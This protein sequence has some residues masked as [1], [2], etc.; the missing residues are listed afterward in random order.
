MSSKFILSFLVT[1][2]V[3]L[4]LT[5]DPEQVCEY[6]SDCI[7]LP[8]DCAPI[9]CINQQFSSEYT[10][11]EICPMIFSTCAAYSPSSCEC[12]KNN[13]CVNLNMANNGCLPLTYD[14]AVSIKN[15]FDSKNLGTYE[16]RV[17]PLSEALEYYNQGMLWNNTPVTLGP[18]EKWTDYCLLLSYRVYYKRDYGNVFE[19]FDGLRVFL[20]TQTS[21]PDGCGLSVKR[22]PNG[23]LVF[24]ELPDCEFAPC[25]TNG[26]LI[27]FFSILCIVLLCLCCATGLCCYCRKKKQ[28]T[29]TNAIPMVFQPQIPMNSMAQ[30]QPTSPSMH[31]IQQYIPMYSTPQ[32]I[33]MYSVPESTTQELA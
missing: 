31:P 29:Q 27:S 10:P 19:T 17:A 23:K 1:T 5:Q 8:S 26:V 21:T 3:A 32:Y 13:L 20:T 22:C 18:N 25:P 14:E 2:F 12:G 9:L 6:N 11:A 30:F 24:K 16:S 15:R 28:T 33:P 4:S 7:P